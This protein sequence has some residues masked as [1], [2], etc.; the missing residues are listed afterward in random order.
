VY[1]LGE[2]LVSGELDADTYR[3]RFVG[4]C[5]TGVEREIVRKDRAVRMAPEGGTRREPVPEP[6]WEQPALTDEEARQIAAGARRLAQTFGVPQDIE[7]A[8][9]EPNEGKRRLSILQ[10]R[11]ITT[12][13]EAGPNPPAPFPAREWGVGPNPPAPFPAREGGAM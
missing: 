9:A 12:L 1:G 13:G 3:V 10:T 2:G 11:A 4:G 6:L 8:L 7:W 5:P